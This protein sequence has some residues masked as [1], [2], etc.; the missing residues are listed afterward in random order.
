MTED[1]N[2][3]DGDSRENAG[4]DRGGRP[5]QPANPQPQPPTQGYHPTEQFPTTPHN[6]A[7]GPAGQQAY[8]AGYP[9]GNPYGP[10]P[11]PTQQFGH[12]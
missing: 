7:G 10:P 6:A 8:G 3:H 2:S 4:G 11:Q 12:P 5:D 9:Q 1:R